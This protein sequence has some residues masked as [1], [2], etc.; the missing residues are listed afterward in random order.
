VAGLIE[1]G[2]ALRTAAALDLYG[3][4]Q[5]GRVTAIGVVLGHASSELDADAAH[6]ANLLRE[7]DLALVDW[8][9][10]EVV[11][12]QGDRVLGYLRSG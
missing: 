7:H 8:C 9:R 2:F 12:G 3:V 6:L 5:G 11:E 4:A 10:V 1:A